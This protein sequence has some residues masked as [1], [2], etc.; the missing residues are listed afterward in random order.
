MTI[1]FENDNDIIINPL[2]KII[3]Y[4]RDNESI[5]LAQIIWGISSIIGLQEGL[6][7]HIDNLTRWAEVKDF[8]VS[9]KGPDMPRISSND[10]D[11]INSHHDTSSCILNTSSVSG[12]DYLLNHIHSGLVHQIL[13]VREESCVP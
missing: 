6:V 5:F 10:I 1:T 3:S 12:T 8:G 11:L 9:D 2:D 13:V 4:G 7:I